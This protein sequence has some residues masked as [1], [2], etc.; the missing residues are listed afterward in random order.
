MYYALLPDDGALKVNMASLI[1]SIFPVVLDGILGKRMQSPR[2]TAYALPGVPKLIDQRP[3]L[4]LCHSYGAD[5]V[6]YGYRIMYGG[7]TNVEGI[8]QGGVDFWVE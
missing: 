6:K 2:L 5:F 8:G 4:S 3:S 1:D 7:F